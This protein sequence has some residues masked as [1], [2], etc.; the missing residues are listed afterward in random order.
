MLEAQPAQSDAEAE[1]TREFRRRVFHW[2]AEQVRHEFAD[3]TW[4]A[5]LHTAVQGKP[6]REAGAALRMSPGAV[7]VAKS[8]VLARLRQEVHQL[9][10]G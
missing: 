5:F 7:Y 9:Q 4:Q 2:A 3:S 8:R 6:A 1:F 10:A